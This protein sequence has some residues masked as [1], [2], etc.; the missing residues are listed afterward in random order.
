MKRIIYISALILVCAACKKENN[1]MEFQGTYTGSFKA[2]Y[3]DKTETSDAEINLENRKFTVI[4]GIKLG[5]GTFTLNDKK[6]ITF[7]DKNLWTSDFD[8]Q[9]V[10]NGSY[11]F[12]ALGDS[13]ILTKYVAQPADFINVYQYRLKRVLQ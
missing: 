6:T 13:L 10:L 4:K 1:A 5:G 8:Y 3:Q 2:I 11:T 9:L 12:E 7:A